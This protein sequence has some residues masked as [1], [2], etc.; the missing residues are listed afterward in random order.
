MKNKLLDKPKRVKERYFRL[1]FYRNFN[2]FLMKILLLKLRISLI[3]SERK[4]I[5]ILDSTFNTMIKERNR[6]DKDKF[7]ALNELYNISM[8]FLLAE[9]DLAAIKIDAFTHSNPWKRN[10]SL[11]IMLLIIHE[12][13]ITKVASGKTLNYIYS[14][15]NINEKLKNKLVDSFRNMK[16]IQDKINYILKD[17]RNNSIAHRDKDAM[18]QY[19]TINGIN[20]LKIKDILN[21]YSIA[22]NNIMKS[23]ITLTQQLSTLSSLLSQYSEKEKN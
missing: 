2:S 15:L 20:I 13:D 22:S 18:L 21:E 11:R 16:K 17:I 9:K 4:R 10:L 1:K 6:L 7:Q 5:K 23:L 8:F 12:R 14:H 3:I 19:Q